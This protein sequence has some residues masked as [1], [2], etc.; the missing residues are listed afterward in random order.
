MLGVLNLKSSSMSKKPSKYNKSTPTEIKPKDTSPKIH[1]R[2]KID[3]Q[4]N[5]EQR[6]DLTDKQKKFIDII[7][8]KKTKVV[9]LSGPAG[10]SKTYIS[11]LAALMLMNSHSISDILYIRS[12]I[13]SA[14]RSMGYLPGASEDKMEPY[15]RPLMDKLEE[16]LP[17]EQILSLLREKRLEGI[18]VGFL[19]GSSFNAKFMIADESQN[20]DYKELTTIITRLGMFSKLIIVGDPMQSDINGR[21]GFSKMADLFNDESSREQG[22]YYLSF[23][24]DDIVRAP[25]LRYI[26]ERIESQ[27]KPEPMFPSK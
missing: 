24:R 23:T 8:D 16:I 17:K 14:S 26:I 22:I 27:T 25:I 18:P 6:N 3:Y 1:Q 11:V 5:I 15:L 10:T 4:L 13:E 2:N 7:L 12:V 21:S 20:L 9:F 19:R